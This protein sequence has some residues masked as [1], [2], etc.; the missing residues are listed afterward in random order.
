MDLTVKQRE[1]RYLFAGDRRYPL[2]VERG[3]GCYIFDTAGKRYLDALGGIAVNALGH[4]HPRITAVLSEQAHR[5]VHTSN[6]V[7]HPYQ[8]LLAE[9]LCE[10]S[11]LDRVFFANSGAEAIEAALKLARFHDRLRHRIVALEHSFH[12][13]TM[14]ALSLTGQPAFRAPFSPYVDDVIF[15]PPNDE[16]ALRGAVTSDTSAVVL[17]PV[18]GEGGVYP[19]TDH[20][21][22]A[23]RTVTSEHGALLV[24]DEI[25]CGLGRTGRRFAYQWA[26]IQPDI[27]TLAKPL[28]A[29]L[30]LS[31]VLMR[32]AVAER[33]PAHLL[34]TT[35][36][37]GPLA[38]RVA[39]EALP[40]IDALISQAYTVATHLAQELDALRTR[41][42]VISAVRAKGM[43]FGIELRQPGRTVVEAALE[44]GL[45]V[46]C[47]HETVLRLLPPLILTKSQASEIV[48]I[49]DEALC[50]AFG[51][52]DLQESMR[53]AS[54][55]ASH[56]AGL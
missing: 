32:E 51:S 27:V 45:L 26:G 24:A 43:M 37:G 18:L 10:W 15:V 55:P 54:A 29:G 14:G 20:Y 35:F 38:C 48:R 40:L 47:T 21:L 12:G 9:T 23:A 6:L 31:A 11:G 13:R 19:L 50:A 16:D 25:Q 33:L 8:G 41:N 28:A 4:C 52:A 44:R 39:L 30:P 17:E 7:S 2:V 46:N 22:R 1:S 36:G 42:P 3:E 53:T 34:G 5:L 49:L 56:R